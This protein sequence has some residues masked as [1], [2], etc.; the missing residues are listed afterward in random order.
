MF[1]GPWHRKLGRSPSRAAPY[2]AAP[3]TMGLLAQPGYP[4]RERLTE[5]RAHVAPPASPAVA[6]QRLPRRVPF[7][8]SGR[9]QTKCNKICEQT[10][11]LLLDVCVFYVC[12]YCERTSVVEQIPCSG[13]LK[14]GYLSSFRLGGGRVAET[15]SGLVP[16]WLHRHVCK[17]PPSVG[18]TLVTTWLCPDCART[19]RQGLHVSP[20]RHLPVT[21]KDRSARL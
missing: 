12:R 1:K 10:L 2:L 16:S 3:Y 11:R 20:C 4:W 5:R 14:A 15:R 17:S 6:C 9:A 7:P 19:G 18:K 13:T 8:S 21:C